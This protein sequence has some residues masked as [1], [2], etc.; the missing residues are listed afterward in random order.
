[1]N[2]IKKRWRRRSAEDFINRVDA[3]ISFLGVFPQL[4]KT[5]QRQKQIRALIISKQTT[6][7]NR[8]KS[9]LIIILNLFDRQDPDKWTVN[10]NINMSYE[11]V[12]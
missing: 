6:I 7:I 9:D 5:I 10:E 11:K 12:R 3:V 8:V 1:M 4:G 2:F